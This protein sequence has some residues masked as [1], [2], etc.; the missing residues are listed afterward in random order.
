MVGSKA[1]KASHYHFTKKKRNRR[2]KY[3]KQKQAKHRMT[4]LVIH[5]S[6]HSQLKLGGGGGGGSGSVIIIIVVVVVVFSLYFKALWGSGHKPRRLAFALGI[7]VGLSRPNEGLA[8]VQPQWLNLGP[9][10]G[11]PW[12]AGGGRR[13]SAV[14]DGDGAGA[15][16]GAGG[17][18]GDGDGDGGGAGGVGAGVGVG[19][20]G[21]V[22]VPEV[23]AT[24]ATI[25]A[26]SGSMATAAAATADGLDPAPDRSR[27]AQETVEQKGPKANPESSSLL[28]EQ[29]VRKR[30]DEGSPE[31]RVPDGGGGGGGGGT[32]GAGR[33]DIVAVANNVW[34]DRAGRAG[35][36]GLG[37]LAVGCCP[38][39]GRRRDDR[40]HVVVVVVGVV[41]VF[42]FFFFLRLVRQRAAGS[43]QWLV[44]GGFDHSCSL[45]DP[46]RGRRW[47]ELLC[48]CHSP[49]VGK[50]QFLANEERGRAPVLAGTTHRLKSKT[51]SGT[52]HHET[53][54]GSEYNEAPRVTQKA[55]PWVGTW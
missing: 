29:G 48:H 36:N 26:D 18:A 25:V 3:N 45:W 6:T 24:L 30:H 27:P 41:V 19:V 34:A 52:H 37:S 39:Q 23:G 55:V 11:R 13:R 44:V 17:G 16:G 51:A 35:G 50:V 9:H 33:A 21:S 46:C 54:N 1:R 22:A 53:G 47:R 14:G 12:L 4:P 8:Q 32:E 28:S 38:C 49:E 2:A 10:A 31:G 42:S 20:G 40:V 7:G 15:G 5:P 43:G